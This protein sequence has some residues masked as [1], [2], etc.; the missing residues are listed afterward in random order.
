MKKRVLF[1][2]NR[3]VLQPLAYITIVVSIYEVIRS[4]FS[5][6]LSLPALA[7]MWAGLILIS[8]GECIES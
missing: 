4:L 5:G 2:L 3:I 8:I 1:W 6:G 7:I